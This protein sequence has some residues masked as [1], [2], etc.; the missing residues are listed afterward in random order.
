M[1]TSPLDRIVLLAKSSEWSK[2]V[3][4]VTQ[5]PFSH[6]RLTIRLATI[7]RQSRIISRS[8]ADAAEAVQQNQ[9]QPD[10]EKPD[11]VAVREKNH[12]RPVLAVD[13][14]PNLILGDAHGGTHSVDGCRGLLPVRC[15]SPCGGSRPTAIIRSLPT[16]KPFSIRLA[17]GEACNQDEDCSSCSHSDSGIA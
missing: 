13:D 9:F 4:K 17:P 6:L 14:R 10:N 12:T 2:I 16:K 11:K 15:L 1:N 8:R 3:S 5:N 7:H